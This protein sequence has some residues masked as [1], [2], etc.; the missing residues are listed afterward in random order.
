MVLKN[1]YPRGNGNEKV[2]GSNLDPKKDNFD[3]SPVSDPKDVVY[4]YCQEKGQWKRSCPEYLEDITKNKVK[5]IGTV[6]TW[7]FEKVEF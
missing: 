4:F 2:R 1:Y 3:I 7:N 5:G 6:R